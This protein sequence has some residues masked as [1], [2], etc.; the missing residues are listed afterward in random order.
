MVSEEVTAYVALGSN[1]GDR[2]AHLDAALAA[3]RETPGVRIEAVSAR[4]QTAPVGGP[5]QGPYLNGAVALTTTLSA[6][7]LLERLHAIEAM[8]GRVRSAARNAPRTLDLD[9]LFFG[10]EEIDAP[11]LRVPHPRLHERAFVLV[12]LREIAADFEHPVLGETISALA[13]RVSAGSSG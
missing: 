10:R 13:Q 3:L 4:H 12:P 9:L 5:L 11:G 6:R 2:E 8:E 7:E 1:V